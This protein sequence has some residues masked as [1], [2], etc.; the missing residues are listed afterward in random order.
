MS[1]RRAIGSFSSCI[2]R[3]I[4]SRGASPDLVTADLNSAVTLFSEPFFRPPVLYPRA[5]CRATTIE[6]FSE[7]DSVVIDTR[8]MNAINIDTTDETVTIG[9]GATLGKIY[10]S[11][12]ARGYALSAGSCPTVG[13]AG[14]VLGGGYGYLSRQFG[15]F[16]DGLK[17]IEIIDAEARGV[18]A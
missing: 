11:I 9:A 16:C 14:H 15:L 1:S 8:S 3:S 6:G 10:R 17:S 13:V 5:I 2:T 12:A 7:S 18:V 4:Y